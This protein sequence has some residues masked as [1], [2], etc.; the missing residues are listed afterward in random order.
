MFLGFLTIDFLSSIFL[1]IEPIDVML[2]PS[3][4]VSM[5]SN[6]MHLNE[7][8]E[9]ELVP[10]RWKSPSPQMASQILLGAME[11]RLIG[12]A[13]VKVFVRTETN[14]FQQHLLAE[15]YKGVIMLI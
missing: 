10:K 6:G 13:D 11:Y 4:F 1:I 9:Y 8:G 15:A 12:S 14:V 3:L 2:F 7:N 5:V